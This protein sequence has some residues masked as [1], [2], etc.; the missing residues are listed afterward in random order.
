M[1]ISRRRHHRSK[2]KP[3]YPVSHGTTTLA[4]YYDPA[5]LGSSHLHVLTEVWVAPGSCF[6][7]HHHQ[8]IE[9]ISYILAGH[10]MHRDNLGHDSVISPGEVQRISSG[11]GITHGEYNDS[12]DEPVH[13]LQ[14]WI[15]PER[16]NLPSNYAKQFFSAARRQN[17]LCLIVSPDGR[18]NSLD[19][20]QDV[21]IYT[22]L[23]RKDI[24]VHYTQATKRVTY[25]HVAK[26]EATINRDSFNSGDGAILYRDKEVTLKTDT[27]AEVL[28]F[29]LPCY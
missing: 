19:L 18:A 7:N 17:Q 28:L 24:S 12:Q 6:P 27:S 8:N 10:L 13:F 22:T 4:G 20:N 9:I 5:F 3:D 14:I 23:L 2:A 29:D 15:E 1:I 16:P 25:I 21:F 26:G 11:V